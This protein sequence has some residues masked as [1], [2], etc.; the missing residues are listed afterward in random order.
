[1][2]ADKSF[3]YIATAQHFGMYLTVLGNQCFTSFN[4]NRD[5]SLTLQ[6]RFIEEKKYLI[7]CFPSLLKNCSDSCSQLM[8]LTCY[9]AINLRA[10]RI[11]TD[12]LV[13]ITSHAWHSP[14][15]GKLPQLTVFAYVEFLSADL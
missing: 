13:R 7:E 8:H 5:V 2:H 3:F 14:N 4:T 11:G 1:V 10:V 9:F 15:R 12:P 6:N